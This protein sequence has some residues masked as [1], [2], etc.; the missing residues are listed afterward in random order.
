MIQMKTLN[1]FRANCDH[2]PK[3]WLWSFA[4]QNKQGAYYIGKR[5]LPFLI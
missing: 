2:N 4:N 5:K 1:N 3:P